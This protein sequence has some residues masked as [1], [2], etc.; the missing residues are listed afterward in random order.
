MTAQVAINAMFQQFN[1]S[2]NA[3][4]SAIVGYV[5][6][7]RYKGKKESAIPDATLYWCRVSEQTVMEARKAIGNHYFESSGLVFVQIFA[8]QAD[9]QGEMNCRAL[10]NLA[11]DAFRAQN[12]LVDFKN[13][14]ALPLDPE[15]GFWRYNTV[16]EY[17]YTEVR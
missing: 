5:P 6:A 2:W 1:D 13:S 8:P 7:V 15:N 16:T 14:R 3:G 12:A 4:A 11:R 9:P 17:D 10:A